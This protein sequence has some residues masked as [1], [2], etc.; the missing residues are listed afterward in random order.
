MIELTK[1]ELGEMLN[2]YKEAIDL[3]PT[4]HYKLVTISNIGEVSL[5][6][7]KQGIDIKANKLFRVK[8]G[9]FTYSRLAAH[10]GS[11][12]LV[13]SILDGAVVSGEMPVFNINTEVVLP[14]YLMYQLSQKNFLRMLC[15]LTRGMG[16][17]RIKESAF[18]HQSI[19]IHK[20]VVKQ[21]QVVDLINS[22]RERLKSLGSN[23][24]EQLQII[25]RLRQSVLREA[26]AGKL[27][28]K[29]RSNNSKLI[30][31]EHH[32][33]KLLQRIKD[34]R[35]RLAGSKRAK[36]QNISLAVSNFKNE[37][38]L[39]EGWAR[40]RFGE[41]VLFERGRFSVRP[42]NDKSCY[43]GKYPFIQIGSLN[44]DGDIILNYKQS[45][46]EKGFS[47]SKQFEKG[48]VVIAI[49][50]G[51]IGNLGVLGIDMC[52]PDSMIGIQPTLNSN[53]KYVLFLLRSKQPEIRKAAYQMAGQP[54]IKIPTLSELMIDL[55]PLSE[56]QVIV[57]HL[58]RIMGS[59]NELEKQIKKITH[60]G[61][62]DFS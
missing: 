27:T 52:F 11:F 5:R 49:V 46:N 7:T 14:D 61:K 48:T 41:Y 9:S 37:P 32:A 21:K 56:Q 1:V 12:G 39:P 20:D 34:D 26:V 6:G 23:Y 24:E 62:G 30:S 58:N 53:Q 28:A 59:I 42:R 36:K 17:I 10:T 4:Q 35:E 45:L 38:A 55:P 47:V 2:Q 25:R 13:P 18:L 51:T 33:T 50:G 3:D 54:N 60:L 22:K 40:C 44:N 8:K 19:S 29:W 16:R 57:E 15:Q 43:G 31:G